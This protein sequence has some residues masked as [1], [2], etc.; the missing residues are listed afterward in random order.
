MPAAAKRPTPDALDVA[1]ALLKKRDGVDKVLKL[2]RY[3]AIFA[4][5][6][7]KRSLTVTPSESSRE[8]VRAGTAFERSI[9]AAR[10]VYRVGK[11]LGNVKDLRD[12]VRDAEAAGKRG[13]ERFLT[14]A[15]LCA[16]LEGAY[17]FLEQGVWLSRAG[18][19]M[20]EKSALARLVRWSA[21][22]EVAS[23]AF[24]IACASE[25]SREAAAEA[26]DARQSLFAE[27]SRALA[28]SGTDQEALASLRRKISVAEKEKFAA[29]RSMCQDIIDGALSLEDAVDVP[30]FEISNERLVNALALLAAFLDFSGKLQD[31]VD[32]F[33]DAK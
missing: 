26:R 13:R 27:A 23:Y 28:G 15:A 30:G 32:S 12:A 1:V 31:A 5:S 20:R 16:S 21:R 11:F 22:A 9:G 3:A 18:V 6:E 10:R 24:S 2:A 33:D 8:F 7:V 17:Y 25:E 4:V 29:I 14:A 19:V